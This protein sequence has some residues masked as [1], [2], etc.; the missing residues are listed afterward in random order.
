MKL[1]QRLE[2]KLEADYGDFPYNSTI[3]FEF[4]WLNLK[5]KI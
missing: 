4:K 2:N 3:L 1:T 5:L